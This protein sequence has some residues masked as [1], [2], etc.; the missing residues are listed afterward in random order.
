[1]NK[2]NTIGKGL[3]E[4]AINGGD[5]KY[6]TKQK[7]ADRYSNIILTKYGSNVT[8]IEP[9]A[10]NG[11]FLKILP[12]IVGYDLKPEGKGIIALDIFDNYNFDDNTVVAGNPPFG[13]NANLAIKIFNHIAN[14]NVKSICFIVPKTFK[15]VSTQDK[16]NLNYRLV[17]EEDIESNAFTVEGK[18]KDVNCV[19]QIWELS[20]DKRTMSKHPPTNGV[21]FTTK[22]KA[23]IAIRRA[24]GKAGQ[25][26]SGLDHSESSTYF[27]K[28]DER[29][30]K[31][32][33]LIDTSVA[34]NTAGV[35]SI[36]K[37]ELLTE[38][39]I[40]VQKEKD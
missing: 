12:G 3:K 13:T 33:A 5:D 7:I 25:V 11:A 23:N 17:L 22:D 39:D 18:N 34:G 4:R 36:S 35:K 29:I 8:Y 1:M 16:L 30:R 21:V 10:G 26:L 32:L 31:M 9:T 38:L 14:Q 27:I 37:K 40:I 28:A 2:H 19:F 15:K 20:L 6:Y 24:G